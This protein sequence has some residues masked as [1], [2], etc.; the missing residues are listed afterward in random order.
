L[1]DSVC[2]SA[3][4]GFGNCQESSVILWWRR[5]APGATA[6]G[7]VGRESPAGLARRHVT[8][9]FTASRKGALGQ[10]TLIQDVGSSNLNQQRR[11]HLHPIQ[12]TFLLSTTPSSSLHQPPSMI[13]V[14]PSNK[15]SGESKA[16]MP[17]KE[18][19]Q[20]HFHPTNQLDQEGNSAPVKC[21]I[22]CTM[23]AS[24]TMTEETK[25]AQAMEK[26]FSPMKQK[27]RPQA[28]SSTNTKTK[29]FKNRSS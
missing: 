28:P 10:N 11:R 2:N 8:G 4:G 6:V 13:F 26:Q 18:H 24:K 17:A 3:E 25:K 20:R 14:S 22:V 15:K 5:A 27:S 19:R 29:K 23:F 7:G 12:D 16:C 9:T 21:V 1:R